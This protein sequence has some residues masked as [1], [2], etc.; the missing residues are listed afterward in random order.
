[1]LPLEKLKPANVW[2][3][4]LS[5]NLKH[6]LTINIVIHQIYIN[7]ILYTAECFFKVYYIFVIKQKIKWLKKKS[8]D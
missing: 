8:L 3:L 6:Y 1:M 7:Q 4:V 5:N 2:S